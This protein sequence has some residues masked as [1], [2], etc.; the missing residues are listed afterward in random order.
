MARVVGLEHDGNDSAIQALLVVEYLT[1]QFPFVLRSQPDAAAFSQGPAAKVT[2]GGN[3]KNEAVVVEDL[4]SDPRWPA[5]FRRLLVLVEGTFH[6]VAREL[7]GE[8]L[9]AGNQAKRPHGRS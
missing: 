9:N 1:N 7:V 4:A 5:L 8:I 3:H 6:A 2:G